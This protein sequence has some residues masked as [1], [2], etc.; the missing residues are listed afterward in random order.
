MDNPISADVSKKEADYASAAVHDIHLWLVLWRMPN[1]NAHA[2]LVALEYYDDAKVFLQTPTH[3]LRAQGVPDLLATA[4]GGYQQNSQERDDMA[5]ADYRCLQKHQA[6][7][8]HWL[9]DD[10]PRLLREI[11][12]PP[13]I[14]CVIGS[15]KLLS[16]PQIAIVGSRKSSASGNEMGFAISRGLA[17]TGL[18][19]CSG[20]AL[21]IDAAAH[22]G[23]LKA[24]KDNADSGTTIAV[25]GT[26]IDISYPQQNRDLRQSI[27]AHGALLSEFPPGASALAAHFPRRNRII[28]GL[29][30]GV[31]V[32]E[33]AQ[34]SGSLITAR[35]ALE[36]NRAV[37]AMPGSIFNPQSRGCHHLIREGA[38]LIEDVA[39]LLEEL[40]SVF[41]PTSAIQADK[42]KVLSAENTSVSG[43]IAV[44]LDAVGFEA[45]SQEI[46]AARSSL[47]P[48]V[49]ASGLVA[50]ELKGLIKRTPAGYVRVDCF[51]L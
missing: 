12:C 2:T 37:W 51:N 7:L 29:S 40:E 44:L 28:S 30:F 18:T 47:D 49:V 26:G 22:S 24:L 39:Q 17:T 50:L 23:A 48:Q 15:V 19:I 13:L 41:K 35:L 1:I 45:T 6:H 4:I 16:H 20:L 46:A 10:Y 8:I 33:A 14:L 11:G 38:V 31:L 25:L 5:I 42:T 21:G 9:H 43:D 36:Q 32:I 3:K 27:V 34:R